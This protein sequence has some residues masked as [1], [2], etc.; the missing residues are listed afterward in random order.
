MLV[1]LWI[2]NNMLVFGAHVDAEFERMRQIVAGEDIDGKLRVEPRDTRAITKYQEKLE[3]LSSSAQEIQD[4]ASGQQTLPK[5]PEPSILE[6]VQTA[7]S[8]NTEML[9]QA[10]SDTRAG[11]TET[12]SSEDSG[13]VKEKASESSQ[14]HTRDSTPHSDN[15]QNGSSKRQDSSR[16]TLF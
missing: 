15:P 5:P 2:M 1:F 16:D 8:T 6:R 9:R 14:K 3:A 10:V 4:L 12:Q 7:V 13:E 11:A